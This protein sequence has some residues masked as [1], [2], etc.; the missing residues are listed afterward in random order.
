M[1]A[2]SFYKRALAA[3]GDYGTLA[4]DKA[5]TEELL[6]I[7]RRDWAVRVLDAWAGA[8][9]WNDSPRPCRLPDGSWCVPYLRP[10]AGKSFSSR[11]AARLAAAEA[12]WPE[13]PESVRA[14]LGERP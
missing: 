12:V 2:V 6:G 9:G 1:S 5:L 13:L 10:I 14:E 4:L 7:L 3:K 11:N 8:M